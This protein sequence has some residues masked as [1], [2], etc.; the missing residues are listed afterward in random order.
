MV[1]G[2]IANEWYKNF[3]TQLAALNC[4][5]GPVMCGLGNFNQDFGIECG[6]G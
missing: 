1:F 4:Q 6:L 3:A 2:L 5:N